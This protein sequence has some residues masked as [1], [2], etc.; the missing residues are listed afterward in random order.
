MQENWKDVVG[1]EQY[2]MVSDRGRVYS[3]R[4][5]II[6]KTLIHK[7]GYEVFAT[8]IGGRSGKALCFKV[9]RLVAE[10][11]LEGPSE[12]LISES[13]KNKYNMVFVNHKDC[14]K[15]NNHISNLEWCTNK[16]NATHASK[17]GLLEYKGPKHKILSN[18]QQNF[19]KSSYIPYCRFN[20]ARALSR[21]FNVSH[22]TILH[23]LNNNPA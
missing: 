10:S 18:E 6:L 2:F 5:N 7:N 16:E 9:H 20:G 11:F 19:I 17:N 22:T 1:Y 23:V 21:K 14:N 4:T 15:L 3:K 12:Y 8:K 13:E